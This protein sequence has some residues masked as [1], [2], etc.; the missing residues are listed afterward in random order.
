[1]ILNT[2]DTF[3]VAIRSCQCYGY[4]MINK[5]KDEM[6]YQLHV[7]EDWNSSQQDGRV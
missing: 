7:L 3:S 6:V 5:E 2:L 1:M 4:D